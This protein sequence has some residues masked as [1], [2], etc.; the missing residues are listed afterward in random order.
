MEEACE[1]V[2][3]DDEDLNRYLKKIEHMPPLDQTEEAEL[4]RGIQRGDQNALE[5]LT[6]AHLRL[7]VSTAKEYLNKGRS[8]RDLIAE[9]R[10]GLVKAAERFDLPKG[11]PFRGYAVWWIRH[12][13]LQAICDRG[14]S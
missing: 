5:R 1:M 9:G 6:E 14:L 2:P 7:V 13:I 4:C 8:L 11:F 3:Y 12:A 10:K